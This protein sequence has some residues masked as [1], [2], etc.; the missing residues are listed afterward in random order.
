MGAIL[1]R[2]LPGSETPAQWVTKLCIFSITTVFTISNL[3]LIELASN[4]ANYK[5]TDV[6]SKYVNQPWHEY[7]ANIYIFCFVIIGCQV[8]V[9]NNKMPLGLIAPPFKISFLATENF[10]KMKFKSVRILLNS[11]HLASISYI[12]SLFAENHMLTKG[13]VGQLL[14]KSQI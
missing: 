13:K 10:Q 11:I 4:R 2:H 3:S 9:I 7:R 14:V 1:G 12:W 5:D 6:S 8:I